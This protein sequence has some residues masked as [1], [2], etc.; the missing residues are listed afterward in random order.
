MCIHIYQWGGPLLV[1]TGWP[2]TCGLLS[3]FASPLVYRLLLAFLGGDFEL[4][5]DTGGVSR[6][7]AQRDPDG[8]GVPVG[9]R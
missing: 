2:S 5:N 8:L 7:R 6:A 9:M 4:Q 1:R 3:W